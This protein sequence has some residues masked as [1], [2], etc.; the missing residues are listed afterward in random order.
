M[1][2]RVRTGLDGKS[3]IAEINARPLAS[4]II[5]VSATPGA[6]LRMIGLYRFPS[7]A[8]SPVRRGT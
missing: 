5:E 8:M 4:N 1:K 6:R 7:P 2:S 3:M